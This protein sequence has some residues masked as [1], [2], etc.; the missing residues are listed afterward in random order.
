LHRARYRE[1]NAC[2][3]R[4]KYWI[5]FCLYWRPAT[6]GSV[7]TTTSASSFASSRSSLTSSHPAFRATVFTTFACIFHRFAFASKYDPRIANTAFGCETFSAFRTRLASFMPSTTTIIEGGEYDFPSMFFSS[8]SSSL[9]VARRRR[10]STVFLPIR[11]CR[12]NNRFVVVDVV[13]V[14]GAEEDPEEK[15]GN[16]RMTTTRVWK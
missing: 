5:K 4:G 13:V 12:Q 6:S 9:V 14:V 3:A 11:F 16:A 2:F 15:D 1:T 7:N 8:S 10:P